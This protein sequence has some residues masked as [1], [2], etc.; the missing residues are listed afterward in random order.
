MKEHCQCFMLVQCESF[1]M[2]DST[3]THTP[4]LRPQE[5]L[6]ICHHIQSKW[7]PDDFLKSTPESNAKLLG[8]IAF[9]LTVEDNNF[10][11]SKN[12]GTKYSVLCYAER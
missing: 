9:T 12:G 8:S 11:L 3:H 2:Y 4:M 6:A 10:C 5:R 1:L 7:R